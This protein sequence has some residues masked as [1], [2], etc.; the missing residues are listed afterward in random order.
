[1][2]PKEL[3]EWYNA[4]RASLPKKEFMLADYMKVQNPETL[5]ESIDIDLES[6]P[7]LKGRLRLIDHLQKLHDFV[8]K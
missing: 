8:N 2:T 5:Y 6:Y 7:E 4:N 1:M 3:I